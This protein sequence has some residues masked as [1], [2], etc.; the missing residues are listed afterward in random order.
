M[1]T[2]KIIDGEFG[3]IKIIRNDSHYLRLNIR[4]NGEIVV[5]A[6]KRASITQIEQFINSNREGLRDNLARINQFNRHHDGD[7][8]GREHTL[9]LRQG[10]RVSARLTDT[11]IIITT[12]STESSV[13][14]QR[15][16]SEA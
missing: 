14:L 2:K 15:R 5:S 1:L 7:V 10:P 11:D 13:E 9:R 8:I 4:P 3:S 6:P 12:T 16:I